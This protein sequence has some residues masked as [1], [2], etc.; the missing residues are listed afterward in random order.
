MNA[1]DIIQAFHES[2][3]N[4]ADI[5]KQ[6]PNELLNEV[7]NK[8]DVQD[9]DRLSNR[10]SWPKDTA[11]ELMNTNMI[12]ISED[13][14]L[15][16][17]W[18]YLRTVVKKIPR[19]I[20]IIF[21]T[22]KNNQLVGI[23]HLTDIMA[24][25]PSCLVR[26]V[27]QMPNH[28]FNAYSSAKE[29]AEEFEKYDLISA[30][31]IDGKKVPLGRITIDDVV[32]I[33][34]EEA[35]TSLKS[36]GHVGGENLFSPIKKSMTSRGFWLGI[37]LLTAIVA[38]FAISNFQTILQNHIILA[39]IMPLIASMGGIATTQSF[40]LV[41][42]AMAYG[43]ISHKHI[44]FLLFREFFIGLG[45]GIF[46]SFLI[47]GLI[48]LIYGNTQVA[49]ITALALTLNLAIACV[50]GILMPFVLKAFSIDPALAGG[51]LLTTITDTVG[52][53]LFLGT[54]TLLLI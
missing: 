39:V 11:G 9:K 1:E 10:I 37:N 21:V 19:D 3:E 12:S 25:K 33:I 23:L 43:T 31:V 18:R 17:V 26:N 45:N 34:R 32:D 52:Y 13:I 47:A 4:I 54:A 50:A 27:M 36:M 40:T 48:V 8:M 49:A 35:D 29:I 53:T 24:N 5:A 2:E 22:N 28:T 30:P 46:W 16:V 38:S 14:T 41:V 44:K 42:R 20:D 51:V 15:D 6:I 7:L